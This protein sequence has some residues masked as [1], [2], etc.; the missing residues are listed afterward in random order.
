M[1]IL[2]DISVLTRDAPDVVGDEPMHTCGRPLVPAPASIRTIACSALRN[3]LEIRIGAG[4]PLNIYGETAD[5]CACD[6]LLRGPP[7]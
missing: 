4:K 6:F 7:Y 2:N 1:A 5:Y 3:Q